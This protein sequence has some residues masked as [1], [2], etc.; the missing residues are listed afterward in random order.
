MLGGTFLTFALFVVQAAMDPR[1]P[2]QSAFIREY[3]FIR[4]HLQFA[5]KI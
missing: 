5:K 3:F 1:D 4:L 2:N